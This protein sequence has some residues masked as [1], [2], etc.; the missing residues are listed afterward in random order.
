MTVAMD[1]YWFT[2]SGL[3]AGA[4]LLLPSHMV[5]LLALPTW[6]HLIILGSAPKLGQ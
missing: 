5:V 6:T 4:A 1:T 2:L 3:F